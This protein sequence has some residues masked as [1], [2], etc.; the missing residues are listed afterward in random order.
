MSFKTVMFEVGIALGVVG[1]ALAAVTTLP[2]LVGP[3]I[4]GASY[5][6]GK[7]ATSPL[8]KPVVV[9]ATVA[10]TAA[11]AAQEIADANPANLDAQHAAKVT[12]AASDA[13][14]RAGFPDSEA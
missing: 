8:D 14:T 13:F 1:A 10:K 9:A 4:A 11:K 2:V 6:A 3:A 12:K 5:L 7:L